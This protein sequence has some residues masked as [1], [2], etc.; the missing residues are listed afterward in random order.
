[1]KVSQYLSK[2]QGS[3]TA[4]IFAK[5]SELEKQ[6]KDIVHLEIGQPDFLP[7]QEVLQ[8][9]ADAV[10]AGKTQYTVSRGIEPLR[11]EIAEYHKAFDNVNV[12]PKNEVVI[13]SGGKLGLFAS[14]WT[15]L[16]HG[17]NVIL[18]NPSWVSYKDII[19]SLGAEPR[20]LPVDSKFDFD[21]EQLRGLIDNKTKALILNSPSNPTGAIISKKNLQI[22]FAICAENDILLVSDEMYSEFT[23]D[24]NE[25]NSLFAI[26]DWKDHGIVVNGMSKTFSMTGFRLGYVIGK[27]AII[28]EV[29]KVNQLTSSCP[30]N[31]AQYGAIEALK[32]IDKMR[33]RIYEIMPKRRDLIT[34]LLS[35]MD[36]SFL[37]PQGAIYAWVGIPN[38]NNSIKWGE[39]LLT[40]VGVAITPGSAFGPDGEGFIRIS[41]ANK[42]EA[43]RD[44]INRIKSFIS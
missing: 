14:L 20:F 26:K 21:E 7:I 23:Y 31:F 11:R 10:L 1:M 41:F 38:M 35:D 3:A 8:A 42:D 29:N 25:H 33:K 34:N 28:N 6:G 17:D 32:R 19:L 4:Q 16:N 9:T 39:K 27:E 37:P 40:E 18:L 22:L 24:G 5:A 12:N 15:V 2:V 36:V 43:L 44:G 13:T 30:T